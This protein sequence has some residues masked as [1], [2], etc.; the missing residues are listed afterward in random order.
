[1]QLLV[2]IPTIFNS[3]Y[4][5]EVEKITEDKQVILL[6]KPKDKE[7]YTFNANPELVI[8]YDDTMPCYRDRSFHA[9]TYCFDSKPE[10]KCFWQYI[11]AFDKVKRIFFTG[12]F[13]AN[14]GD[15]SIPELCRTRKSILTNYS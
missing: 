14:Q 7:Y 4:N 2:I 3:L 13:T 11:K 9:D 12:M 15:L 1:M 8:R 10:M 5:E 6:R